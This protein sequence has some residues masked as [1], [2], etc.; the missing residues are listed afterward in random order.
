MVE[1]AVGEQSF[2]E[3]HRTLNADHVDLRNAIRDT[4]GSA[5]VFD[6]EKTR[7]TSIIQF[8][9]LYGYCIYFVLGRAVDDASN[10]IIAAEVVSIPT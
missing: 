5:E 7:E 6:H 2:L 4:Y 9:E 8:E 10:E 1:T 3:C